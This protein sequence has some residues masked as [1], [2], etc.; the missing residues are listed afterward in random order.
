[1]RKM[2]KGKMKEA[3][4]GETLVYEKQVKDPGTWTQKRCSEEVLQ[5]VLFSEARLGTEHTLWGFRVRAQGQE[6]KSVGQS[7]CFLRKDL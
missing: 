4:M 7:L 1:M 2:Q 3:G 6:V 5:W